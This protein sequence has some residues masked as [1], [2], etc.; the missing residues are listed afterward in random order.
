MAMKRILVVE[1]EEAQR[2]LLSEELRDAGFEVAEATNGK[3]A[4]QRLQSEEYDL[5]TLDLR[6][7]EMDGL[8]VLDELAERWPD[9]PVVVCTAYGDKKQD[10]RTW[11]AADY[12]VKSDD[13][14]GLV[15]K[16]KQLLGLD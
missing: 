3:E 12:W 1:D 4:L 11:R 14:S 6:M 10:F 7:P 2:L 9:L 13:L 5:V 16:V 15:A 8:K